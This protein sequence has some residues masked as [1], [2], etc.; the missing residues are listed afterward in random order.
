MLLKGKKILIMGVANDMSM[1]WGIAKMA[2]E[3]GAQ[4]AMPYAM[5]ALEKRVRPLAESVDAKFVTECN[6]QDDAAMDALFAAIEREWG[7]LDGVLHA[8]AFSDRNELVGRYAD[9]TRENF[10]NTMDVSVYSFVD[11]A[12]R[13]A[14]LM[15]NGGSILTL[16]YFGGEKSIPN[17]N[18]MGVAKSALDSSV[19]YL[20]AD[21]GASGIRVNAVSAGPI[22]TLASSGVGGFKSILK[23]NEKMTPLRRNMTL[24]DVAGAAVYF[25]SDLSSAVTGEIHHADCGYSSTGMIPN[26]L[27]EILLRGLG[28]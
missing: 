5:P 11:V 2:H 22:V 14:P 25:F 1:A 12:R 10:K 20:A 18:V 21:L 27:K 17:Y 24:E 4:I 15:K 28:D 23:L 7:A 8:I 26:E 3:H 6:V 19:R 16:T 9:T 13:A